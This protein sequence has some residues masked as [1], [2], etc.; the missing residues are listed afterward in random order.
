MDSHPHFLK[1]SQLEDI[2]MSK[3]FQ[4]TDVE[5]LRDPWLSEEQSE[6]A[7]DGRPCDN[8]VEESISLIS[9][10]EVFRDFHPKFLEPNH[11]L[12]TSLLDR[13]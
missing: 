12:L 1:P 8:V 4:S 13:G 9:V 2:A 5:Y 10:K 3:V 7:V 11:W 6:A